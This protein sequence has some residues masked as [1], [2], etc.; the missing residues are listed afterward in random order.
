MAQTRPAHTRYLP[1]LG[2]SILWLLATTAAHAQGT[3]FTY[4]G[5]L[6]DAGNPANNTY[7]L[8]F[9]LFDTPT[10]GTGVQQGPTIST[11]G[12]QVTAGIFTVTLD[13]DVNVFTGPP[14]F[15]E[16]GVR[17]AGS[18]NPHTVLSPR[19]P[20]T[21]SPYA[22]QTI[23]ALQLGGL[24]ASRFLQFD[25]SGNAGIGTTSP[26]SKLDV[27]GNLVLDPGSNPFLFTAAVGGEQ[28]RYLELLNSP[29][30]QGASGLKAGGILVSDYFG[31]ANPG[32]NNLIVKGNVGIG[33]AS[34]TARLTI[35]GAGAFNSPIASRFDLF[36]STAG[37]GFLQ[38]VTDT[39]LLQFATTGGSTVMVM[40]PNLNVGVG[41][42]TPQAKLQIAGAG[43]NGYTL[44]VEGNVTQNLA[45]GGFVK[46]MLVVNAN[47]SIARCFNSTLAG[48]AAS[49]VP[50]GFNAVLAGDA[51]LPVY[52]ID[53]GFQVDNR[54]LAITP[55]VPSTSRNVAA[56]YAIGNPNQISVFIVV[57]NDAID[58]TFAEFMVIVY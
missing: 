26:Q 56:N 33:T 10:V 13:S 4:Q 31:F 47:G 25:A 21:S 2:F 20:I 8:Q 18:P 46:A 39:G 1:L 37:T 43:T 6:T 15:L 41:T 36:N 52:S 55:R 35:N 45:N 42:T 50:C 16:I 44:G 11:P 23:N 22:I 9:K 49:V 19:Q 30:F 29:S 57:T 58:T 54:F 12:V 34:P 51:A 5:K 48:S 14:R 53:F 17:P 7:D 3:A 32:K 38:H 40:A 28:S 27:R 24:P